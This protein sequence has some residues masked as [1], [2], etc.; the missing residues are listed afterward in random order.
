MQTPLFTDN[1]YFGSHNNFTFWTGTVIKF[2]SFPSLL[3]IIVMAQ[4]NFYV[5]FESVRTERFAV[6]KLYKVACLLLMDC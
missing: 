2:V 3:K 4:F 6:K 5:F 1:H